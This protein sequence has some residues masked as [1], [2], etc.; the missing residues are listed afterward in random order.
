MVVV[1][2]PNTVDG[3]GRGTWIPL[4]LT[5]FPRLHGSNV[6]NY[7]ETPASNGY[8]DLGQIGVKA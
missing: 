2:N 5:N 8:P 4:D 6:T 3:L 7:T 1:Y